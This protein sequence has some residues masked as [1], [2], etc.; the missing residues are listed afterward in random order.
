[1]E[2]FLRKEAEGGQHLII[3]TPSGVNLLTHIA[4]LV[5]EHP[6][7][8]RVHVLIRHRD[9]H[10]ACLPGRIDRC[11]GAAYGRALIVG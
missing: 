6:L 3:T 1:M 11:E 4:Q 9:R 2:L 10:L 7:E 8:D 5:Y